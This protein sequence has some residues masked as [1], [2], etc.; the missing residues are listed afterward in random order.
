MK[1]DDNKPSR[2]MALD[3]GSKRIGVAVSDPLRMTATPMSTIERKDISSD[4]Q[5]LLSLASRQG[6]TRIIVGRPLTLTGRK[7]PVVDLVER[8]VDALRE[9]C[10]I[11]IEWADERLSTKEAESLMS[12]LGIKV[13]QR[14]ARRDQYAAALILTWYLQEYSSE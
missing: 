6:V 3:V 1:R 11:R 13:A 12:E 5:E 8:F 10:P 2:W 9:K 4:I 14:R 7:A